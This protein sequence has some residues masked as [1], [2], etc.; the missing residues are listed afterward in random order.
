MCCSPPVA[1]FVSDTCGAAVVVAPAVRSECVCAIEEVEMVPTTADA[2]C[3]DGML[4]AA[5]AVVRL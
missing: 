3:A 1:T 4:P 2:M 5:L